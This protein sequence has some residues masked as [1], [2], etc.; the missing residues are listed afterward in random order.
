M[1]KGSG[2]R[3]KS[4]QVVDLLNNNEAIRSERDKARALRNK[5]V[6]I[7]SRNAAGPYGGYGNSGGYGGSSSGGYS[8]SDSYSSGGRYDS[9]DSGS[10]YG[11]DS[12]SSGNSNRRSSTSEGTSGRYG[13]GAYDSN[14]PPRYDDDAPEPQLEE[15]KVVSKSAASTKS[16]SVSSTTSGGKLKVSI[17]KVSTSSTNKA[18]EVD[19]MPTADIDLIGGFESAPSAAP[20]GTASI[21]FDP[22]GS[23]SVAS[24]SVSDFD[25][26]GSNT[27]F[28]SAASPASTFD[29]FNAA[30]TPAPAQP[31]QQPFA[32]PP[33]V[34][35]TY[36][37]QQPMMG[38][39]PNV[40][41][42]NNNMFSPNPSYQV[43]P[44]AMGF[45]PA[46]TNPQQQPSLQGFQPAP[47]SASPASQDIDFGDFETAPQ[48]KNNNSKP[49]VD[50]WGD[51]TKLVDLNKIEKNETVSVKQ[52]S[53][54]A[55]AQNYANNSFAGLDGF[56]KTPQNM[57]SFLF[58]LFWCSPCHTLLH[59]CIYRYRCRA[60][61][62]TALLE[63]WF[64]Q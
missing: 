7:D 55:A 3:E 1:D 17:K 16:A 33:N 23:N 45:Q 42:V 9:H 34:P 30:P 61:L 36:P 38:S 46:M 8:G 62:P 4:K 57:V 43:P 27:T 26:F 2:V 12:Y 24:N 47:T 11:G 29:P 56:S 51:L 37:Q 13:G 49:V 40:A 15:A 28:T 52:T 20:A 6:G 32:F 39:Y 60:P 50:K 54:N 18:A 22:F 53:S 10:R 48:Q 21:D 31:A 19:L 25:P 44:A 14:R 41:S 35:M 5:F 63:V 58:M 59:F 64:L